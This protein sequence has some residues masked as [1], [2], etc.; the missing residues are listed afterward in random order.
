MQQ[1]PR[2]KTDHLFTPKMM[3]NANCTIGLLE[4]FGSFFAFYW[5]FYDYGF[6]FGDLLNSGQGYKS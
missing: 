4:S 1:P 3:I 5:V 2:K 6:T